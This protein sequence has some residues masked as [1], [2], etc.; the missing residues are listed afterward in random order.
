[1]TSGDRP[2]T[3]QS[4]PSHPC[5]HS[6]LL[7]PSR[8]RHARNHP[9]WSATRSL[10]SHKLRWDEGLRLLLPSL[11]LN[12]LKVHRLQVDLCRVSFPVI[13]RMWCQSRQ[14]N[15][16]KLHKTPFA[17]WRSSQAASVLMKFARM[18]SVLSRMKVFK[19]R[20]NLQASSVSSKSCS[21][22]FMLATLCADKD[23]ATCLQHHIQHPDCSTVFTR[24]TVV[25]SVQRV[26]IAGVASD[27]HGKMHA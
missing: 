12:R 19:R 23:M 5:S 24:T 25:G 1:M 18:V 26:W 22:L 10:S 2:S 7:R 14:K 21:K 20:E 27:T 17:N 8:R 11:L 16:T 13:R 3:P 15:R 4:P 6:R 9:S